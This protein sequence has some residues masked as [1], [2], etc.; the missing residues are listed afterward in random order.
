MH[1]PRLVF[2]FGL[3]FFFAFSTAAAAADDV[4]GWMRQS[5]AAPTPA[6]AK[7]VPAV[8]LLNEQKV[9]MDGGKLVT[10]TNYAVKL[11]SREG[12][13]SAVARALYL[14][15][16]GKVREINAW[17]IRADGTSKEFDKK[18]VLDLIADPD[19]I[20][21]EYRIK[22]IDASGEA[23][24]GAV[25]GYTVVTEDAP[26]FYHDT[27]SFQDNLPVIASR[28]TLNLPSGW[29]ATG[30]G[31]RFGKVKPITST[32]FAKACSESFAKA[33][34]FCPRHW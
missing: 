1:I 28:Y 7:D 12:R 32:A 22:V 21:N 20:Y 18:S 23:D 30:I 29:K 10:Q 11:L 9:T 2:F 6:Y 5:A 33:C 13:S 14:V 34:R 4:P 25:F 3:V 8:V 17:L 19:D 31:A 27:W 16:A 15:S 26:L 24:T